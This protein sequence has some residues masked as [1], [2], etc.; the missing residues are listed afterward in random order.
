MLIGALLLPVLTGCQKDTVPA[1][2]VGANNW[3]GYMP[4]FLASDLGF[5]DHQQ[6]HMAEMGSAT[7]VLR[8]LRNG[9]LDA[10]ALTLD[11]TITALVSGLD[12]AVVLVLDYSMGA[13]AVLVK[14]GITVEDL[15]HS[16][17]V[18][19]QTAVGAIMLDGMRE[20]LGLDLN[21]LTV[22]LVPYDQHFAAYQQED[23][24]AVVTFEP[25]KSRLENLGARV[26]FDSSQIPG[27]IVDVLVIRKNSLNQKL[28]Y[29]EQLIHGYYKARA[30][31]NEKSP[32]IRALLAKRM[33]L[34]SEAVFSAFDGL[35]LPDRD[36]T[37]KS[38]KSCQ[39]HLQKTAESLM[40][41]MSERHLIERTVTMKPLC[42]ARALIGA[43]Q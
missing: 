8:A 31:L 13:D 38:L 21:Q 7:E 14:P 26:L 33:R 28:H 40:E 34:P 10:A 2:T 42:D 5:V 36:Q 19:E 39:E 17:I 16:V 23:V 25:V 6:V 12:L 24:A 41:L 22:R 29:L 3:P 11:E 4:L 32:E 30:L 18:A 1:L 20:K 35:Q 27:R 9:N 15:Q 37:V 43:D